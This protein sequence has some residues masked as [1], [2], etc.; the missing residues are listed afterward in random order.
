MVPKFCEPEWFDLRY[1]QQETR[2]AQ[3]KSIVIDFEEGLGA[4]GPVQTRLAAFAE[5]LY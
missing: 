1:L 2:Q 3:I 4:T 5:T